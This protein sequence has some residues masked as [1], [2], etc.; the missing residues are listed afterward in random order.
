LTMDWGKLP[1]PECR[2]LAKPQQELP[3]EVSL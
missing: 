2:R 1:P 3:H